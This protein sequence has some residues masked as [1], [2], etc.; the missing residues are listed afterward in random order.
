M[1][2]FDPKS[3]YPRVMELDDGRTVDVYQSE[4]GDVGCVVWD[5]A[6]VLSKFYELMSTQTYA[7]IAKRTNLTSDYCSKLITL[8]HQVNKGD[9]RVIELGSGTGCVGIIAASMGLVFLLTSTPSSCI[10]SP[11]VI[12]LR[13]F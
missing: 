10:L 13:I 3:L 9:S 11:V 2:S 1:S 12:H 6:I 5:A 4:L 7:A 8:V